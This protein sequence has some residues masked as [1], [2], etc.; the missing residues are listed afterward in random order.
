MAGVVGESL[1]EAVEFGANLSEGGTEG[2]VLDELGSIIDGFDHVV[3]GSNLSDKG[4]VLIL[5]GGL[6]TSVGGSV[7]LNVGNGDSDV[8]LRLGESLDGVVS[9]LGVGLD[10]VVVVV[11]LLVEVVDD[12]I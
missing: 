12:L 5:A 9:E 7:V 3:D 2:K 6:F 8:L 4:V 11:N 1:V 10:L